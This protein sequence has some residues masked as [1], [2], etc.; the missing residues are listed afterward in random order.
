M[1][2]TADVGR[3]FHKDRTVRTFPGNTIICFVDPKVH[4][5]IYEESVWAQEQLKAMRCA[6]KYGFLPPSSLHMTVLD[7]ITDEIRSPE[8]WSS[9]IPLDLPLED[10]DQYFI[11]ALKDEAP[12]QVT[13]DIGYEHMREQ[14]T[15]AVAP[16][17][18][19][20]ERSI[21]AFRNRMADLTGVRAPDFSSY[22]FHISLAY[23]LIELDAYDIRERDE[24][25]LKIDERLTET[26]GI[27]ETDPPVL[28]FFDDMFKFVPVH[29]RLSLHTRDY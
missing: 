19:E 1:N 10:T 21:W 23:N 26:F 16:I 24:T 18:A 9:H 20:S 12:F 17:N 6:D 11:E 8:R 28:T 22:G 14:A 5:T 25:F 2:Y 4:Q 3:K 29:A 7:L 27:F 15:L 13:F